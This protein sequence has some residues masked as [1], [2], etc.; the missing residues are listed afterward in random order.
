LRRTRLSLAAALALATSV[1]VIAGPTAA[2][3]APKPKADIPVQIIAM[4]DF[5]GRITAQSKPDVTNGAGDG[6]L[7]TAPGKD[8]KYGGS[9]DIVFPVGSA[10]SIAANV[11]SLQ[12]S[13]HQATNPEARSVFVGAGDLVSASPFE[14]SAYKDEPTIEALNAMGLDMSSVG[15]HEFDRGTEELRRISAATDNSYS[16]DV[17]ACEGIIPGKTGCFGEGEHAFEG[18]DFP[19]LAANVVSKETGEPILPPYQ[20]FDVGGGH[21]MALIGIV[22]DTTPT[23]VSPQGVED[24]TFIDE[25]T[26]INTWVPRLIS[27]GVKAIGVLVHEGGVVDDPNAAPYINNCTGLKGDLV[28][29][30]NKVSDQVDLIVSAHTHQAYNCLLPVPGGKPRLVTSAG[31]YGRLLTDIRVMIK[32]QNGDVDRSATYQATN[33]PVQ[34]NLSDPAVQRIVDYWNGRAA[35][36]GNVPVGSITKDIPAPNGSGERNREAA[37]VNLVADTQL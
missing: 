1:G 7:A 21:E 32:P 10:A 4:N 35:V 8:G 6:T 22:T 26:A 18:A 29:I 9:D 23:I 33:V 16:D 25:A 34:R 24:V 20:K 30:N 2:T 27:Q 15:N 36:T 14:S 13:F 37:M 31:Y 11:Q 3:A 17:T 19:Y 12:A 5:H 28:D